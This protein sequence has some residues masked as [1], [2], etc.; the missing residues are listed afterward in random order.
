VINP[1]DRLAATEKSNAAQIMGRLG[2]RTPRVR[3]INDI[4]AF[5]R[6]L[7]GLKPPLLIRE[8]WGHGQPA[9][10]LGH[11]S[12]AHT[13]PLERFRQPIAVE[14]IDTSDPRDG[15]FRKY[16]YLVAG[17]AGAPRHLIINDH[18]E[19]RPQRRLM[20]E[21]ARREELD[22]LNHSDSNHGPLQL[23]RKALGLD[24]VGFDYSYDRT[25]QMVV[26]EANAYPDLNYPKN[27][28]SRHLFPAVERS[29][30]AVAKLYL[31]RA[32]LSVPARIQQMLAAPS[33][34]ISR[35]PSAA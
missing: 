25:G 8:N 28:W 27:P 11:A 24:V 14:F 9:V 19:V 21:R 32:D 5:R 29:F 18:W 15:L 4:A 6:D 12:D 35:R 16:R 3:R 30:A 34:Q 1:V 31:E 17:D 13:V 7:G 22:Y 2:I 20:T 33:C 26:W 23:A 10:L